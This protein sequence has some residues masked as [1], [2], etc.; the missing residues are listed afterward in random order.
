MA[1]IA[2]EGNPRFTPDLVLVGTLDGNATLIMQFPPPD[3]E[4]P[5]IIRPFPPEGGPGGPAFCDD[6]V[7][8]IDT[9]VVSGDSESSILSVYSIR[10]TPLILPSLIVTAPLTVTHIPGEE[11][12][13]VLDIDYTIFTGECLCGFSVCLMTHN[14]GGVPPQGRETSA[15]F[16]YLGPTAGQ[17]L[18]GLTFAIDPGST[19]GNF[20]GWV[21]LVNEKAQRLQLMYYLNESLADLPD[22]THIVADAAMPGVGDL[23]QILY[24]RDNTR[25]DVFLSTQS[26]GFS[27]PIAYT[28]ASQISNGARC[29]AGL[30]WIGTPNTNDVAIARWD[31][32]VTLTAAYLVAN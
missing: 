31:K 8:N 12:F 6:A 13:D 23:V 16:R 21:L 20:T 28:S 27:A 26:G 15:G 29:N 10:Q 32:G 4:S 1:T 30:V 19:L 11:R 5:P 9:G 3:A 24:D 17:P 7:T 25:I 18:T 2:H 22:V 14:A